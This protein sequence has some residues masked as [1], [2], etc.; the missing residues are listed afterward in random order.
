M[1]RQHGRS[2]RGLVAA[3]SIVLLLQ[4]GTTLAD[5]SGDIASVRVPA[6]APIAVVE[7][8][9]SQNCPACP[10]A[11]KVFDEIARDAR[12]RG[13]RVIPLTYH[14][15]YWGKGSAR[16]P[17]SD[18]AYAERQAEYKTAMRLEER[19]TPQMIVNGRREFTGSERD[20]ALSTI[21]AALQVPA[22]AM[23]T[24]GAPRTAAVGEG[25]AIPVEFVASGGTRDAMAHVLLVER[26]V[27]ARGRGGKVARHSNIVRAMQ[28]V[29]YRAGVAERV[30][31]LPPAG[32]AQDGLAIVVLVQDSRTMAILGATSTDLPAP[33]AVKTVISAAAEALP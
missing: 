24:L 8:F 11:E 10:A 23:V 18:P 13:T 26:E 32:S 17:L 16:D 29:P 6:Q 20:T 27:T 28:S 2:G 1:L 33:P 12:Q 21:R 15:D 9:T 3:G 5:A 14:V 22:R 19:Y 25:G 30:N 31:I 7:M 4:Q